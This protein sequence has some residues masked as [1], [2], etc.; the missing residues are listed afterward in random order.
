MKK[1][2]VGITFN[3]YKNDESRT[4]S[5][6][7]W[8]FGLNQ[9]YAKLLAAADVVPVGIIPT[10][11]DVRSILDTVDMILLTGGPDPDPALYGQKLNGSIGC[12]RERPLWEMELYRIARS[13][14]IP[15]FGVCLG[16]Q[17]IA[18]AEGEQLIQD[19]ST[20]VDDPV[21]HDGKADD[22]RK[23]TVKIID[24]T[25]LGK[26]LGCEIEVCSFH[27]QSIAG[28]P[29]GYRLAAESQDGVIEAMESDDGLVVAVQWHPER[30]FTGPLILRNLITR[31]FGDSD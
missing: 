9:S 22:P 18:V 4:P 8:L 12:Y 21:D 20:Q 24:G 15:V 11:K 1:P 27:H 25:F 26:I 28:I 7:K 10:S 5:Y 2:V 29:K 6:G 13:M 14:K 30:D 3:W 23:H 31:Y 19:I 16:I 17:L